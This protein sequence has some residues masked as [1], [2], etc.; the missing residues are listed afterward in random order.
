M[1]VIKVIKSK[2][3]FH[4]LKILSLKGGSVSL[5]SRKSIMI[6]HDSL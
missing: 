2:E 3:E 4:I 6:I 1:K 5:G